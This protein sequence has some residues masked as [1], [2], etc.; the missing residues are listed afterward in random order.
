MQTSVVLFP[1]LLPPCI[2]LLSLPLLSSHFILSSFPPFLFSLL[3]SFP[4]C[5][6]L[7]F[8]VQQNHWLTLYS[9]LPMY[10]S[11]NT[12]TCFV[13]PYVLYIALLTYNKQ[14]KLN[15]ACTT[16]Y[17]DIRIHHLII[18]SMKII[19]TSIISHSDLCFFYTKKDKVYSLSKLLA[20]VQDY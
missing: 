18:T 7:S 8:P 9:F 10:F 19:N 2:F 17:F 15:L 12:L 11:M 6:I 4:F 3:S 14:I 13:H 16:W 5:F 20:S 1:F